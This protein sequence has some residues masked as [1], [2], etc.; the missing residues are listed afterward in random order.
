[1]KSA[2]VLTI[3][4]AIFSFKAFADDLTLSDNPYAPVVERNIFGL[5]PIPVGPPA[6]AKPPDPPSKI[7][8]NGIMNLFGELQ[9]LFK[10]SVSPKPGL[11]PHDQ[12]YTMSVGERSDG[13]EVTKIDKQAGVIT[14]DNHGVIQ[15]LS[16]SKTVALGAPQ[17]AQPAMPSP[18]FRP[19]G[20]NGF[21][22]RQNLNGNQSFSGNSYN[23]AANPVAATAYGNNSVAQ[24]YGATPNY[25]SASV[26]P[27]NNSQQQQLSPEAQVIAIEA[28]RA[29]LQQSASPGYS[30]VMLPPTPLTPQNTPGQSGPSGPPI[31]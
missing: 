7:T 4:F 22:G 15:E 20:M 23:A 27:N 16:L 12:S 10:V 18:G 6:D 26:S 1:M 2:G 28:E 5:V 19:P 13:I 9:V 3:L 8:P 21:R 25:G 14:F 11:P 17:P 31:P 24:S 29:R 30:P